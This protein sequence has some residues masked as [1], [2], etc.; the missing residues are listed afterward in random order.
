MPTELQTRPARLIVT[1]RDASTLLC[2][3]GQLQVVVGIDL[4]FDD[5]SPLDFE[6]GIRCGGFSI[7]SREFDFHRIIEG[8][9]AV[10]E[11]DDI[12][13]DGAGDR[14]FLAL[15]IDCRFRG[16]RDVHDGLELLNCRFG[17]DDGGAGGGNA[18]GAE[19]NHAA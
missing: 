7:G 14:H 9:S 16:E 10:G 8:G 18:R 6:G 12:P 19:I 13:S 1:R 5:G 2:G 11:G 15:E 17:N 4:H 3:E